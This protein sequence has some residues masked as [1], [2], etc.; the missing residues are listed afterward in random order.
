MSQQTRFLVPLG[1]H[2]RNWEQ[3]LDS[4]LM[5]FTV[6]EPVTLVMALD[7]ALDVAATAMQLEQT[8]SAWGYDPEHIPDIELLGCSPEELEALRREAD[9]VLPDEPIAP[10]V[11]RQLAGLLA[12]PPAPLVTIVVL[13][14]NQ[15]DY[16]RLCLDSL[17]RHTRLP[18]EL[19][20][21]DNASQDG[22]P[23]F[24]RALEGVSLLTN[25]E[26]L[27]YA[28]ACNQGIAAAQGRHVVLL[29]NDTIVTQGWLEGLLMELESAP[30]VGMVGPVSNYAPTWQMLSEAP[31]TCFEGDR[32]MLD[33]TGLHR[34]AHDRAEHLKGASR[35]VNQ[36][37]GFC[38]LIRREAI[39]RI[40]GLDDRFGIGFFEDTDFA[41][42]A[43]IAGFQL[44][45]RED[46]FIHHFGSRTF[47]G[48][49]LDT[50]RLLRENGAKFKE[51]WEVPTDRDLTDPDL[52]AELLATPFDPKRHVQPLPE[53]PTPH[54]PGLTSIVIL[55]FNQLPYTQLCVESVQKLTPEAHELI[56]VDNGS[57]DGTT[58]YFQELS[59][60]YANVRAILNPDNHGFAGGCNQGIREARG[61]YLLMLNNDTLVTEGWLARMRA[62]LDA[63]AGLGIVG[64]VSNYV[65]GPQLIPNV[66]YDYDLGEIMAYARQWGHDHAGQGFWLDKIVG[67]CMLIRRAV[68]ERIGGFDTRFGNGNFEDD[69]FCLRARAAGYRIWVCEDVFIHHFGS[70]TFMLLG[71]NASYRAAMD[72]GWDLFK[73]K[74]RL[75]METVRRTDY[76]ACSLASQEF[77]PGRHVVAW[78]EEN[79]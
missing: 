19:L 75:P 49:K 56:L 30:E 66:P 3:L 16:T 74:W 64:P 26:N 9:H 8:I 41:Y 59:R 67:F 53:A 35:P 38:L 28:R 20:V 23:E 48:A 71:D 69:D 78:P 76:D 63:D 55:G 79:V 13:A 70:R 29:N 27:G 24:L 47:E 52:P 61:D 11:L 6:A 17:R 7:S 33:L 25:R 2:S 21:V 58:V 46:V 22:T 12:P 50:E 34:L 32:Q 4:Y 31:Y 65:N 18:Y 42:R 54:Q 77:D 36:L 60:T 43:R 1:E 45:V 40:G 72:R 10:A 39:E 14:Y 68:I 51:K 73:E 44:R 57:T 37:G 62:R 15:L 5:A